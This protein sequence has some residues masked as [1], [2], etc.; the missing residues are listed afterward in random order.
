MSVEYA[1]KGL[2][3]VLTPQAN[4]T[5][6]PE[7]AIATP[8][9]YAWINARMTSSFGTIEE[10]LVDYF[11]N[12]HSFLPQFANAPI[13]SIAFAC[14]GTSYL[15]GIEAEDRVLKE[16]TTKTGL[17]AMSAATSVCKALNVLGAK[18]IGLVSPYAGSLDKACT[19]YWEA[20]GFK[21]TS[22]RNAEWS[23][24]HFHPIYSLNSDSAQA[25]L[26]K[27]HG[28]DV[29]A[30]VMLGTG[31]PTL[32]PIVRTPYVGRAPVF[33]CMLAIIWASVAAAGGYEPDRQN[34]IDWIEARHWKD[35]MLAWERASGRGG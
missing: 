22:K 4:T 17:P 35:R 7:Y 21:V 23:G 20:R 1:A 5:V 31:M 12:V 11:G 13:Q 34:L 6:E 25:C 16:I 14:T 26:D 3:G 32:S 8:P 29:D 18:K 9:G 27:M 19:P 10:R 24:E 33:S 2:I 30:I 15:A 28:D